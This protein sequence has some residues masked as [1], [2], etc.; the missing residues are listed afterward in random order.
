PF[1]W[2]I[3][4]F[5]A[6]GIKA[7]ALALLP[8]A[9][10]LLIHYYWVLSM[11]VSFEEASL[12]QAEKRALRRAGVRSGDY[13]FGQ[14]A[15]KARRPAFK[16]AASGPLEIAFLWK[17]LLSTRSFFNARTWLI[18]A[19]VIVIGARLIRGMGP[20]QQN[21]L[22]AVGAGVLVLGLYVL[23]FGP[24]IA[25]QDLRNDLTHADVLKTYPI[26]GW[27]LVLGE[28]LAPLAIL[29]G[30]IW[31][32]LLFGV[33]AIQPTQVLPAWLDP[34]LRVTYA[35]CLALVTPALVTLQ[36]L[37]PNAAAVVFPAWFQATRAMGGGIDMMGQRLIFVFGQL[38]IIVLALIPAAAAAAL[39]IFSMQ[40]IIGSALAVILTTVFVL[41]VLIAEVWCG[42]WWLGERF[43]RF[44]LSL[45]QRP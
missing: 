36:L 40:W 35:A 9:A 8:A 6:N 34:S 4:P 14:S 17:N 26:P 2:I 7:F 10:L 1:T 16:L 42:L 13:R 21:V 15:P 20:L 45:E 39:L 43:D 5:F 37:V 19:A 3:A 30:I 12:V 23:M 29:T 18:C 44:D 28:L 38:F 24:L 22:S 32:T 33:C 25:R 27:R 11:E 31:L 41:V